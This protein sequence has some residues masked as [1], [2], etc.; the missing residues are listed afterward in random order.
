MSNALR[1]WV[2]RAG[3]DHRAERRQ[4]IRRWVVGLLAFFAIVAATT[5]VV[6]VVWNS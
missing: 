6:R 3:R 1:N 5:Y 2:Y 4:R